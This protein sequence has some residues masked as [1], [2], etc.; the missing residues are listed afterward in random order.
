MP[1]GGHVFW[2]QVI[3]SFPTILDAVRIS[4]R[5]MLWQI[6]REIDKVEEK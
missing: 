4:P 6:S 1:Q 2:P 3:C 5:D